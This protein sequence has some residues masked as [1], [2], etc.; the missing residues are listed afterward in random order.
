MG[1]RGYSQRGLVPAPAA[2][3]AEKL[4]RSRRWRTDG[5]PRLVHHHVTVVETAGARAARR[6]VSPHVRAAQARDALCQRADVVDIV[7]AQVQQLAGVLLRVP[8][9]HATG[10]QGSIRTRSVRAERLCWTRPKSPTR[11]FEACVLSGSLFVRLWSGV[12][13][14][15][16]DNRTERAEGWGPISHMPLESS[17][18]LARVHC[19]PHNRNARDMLC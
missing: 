3:L 12:C 4:G 18:I 19:F 1:S 15:L 16:A 7:D 8:A 13:S 6:L 9:R 2:R 14:V 10:R 17:H 11:M 5:E